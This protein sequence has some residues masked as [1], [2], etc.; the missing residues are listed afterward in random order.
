MSKNQ[1][2]LEIELFRFDGEWQAGRYVAV[3]PK[4]QEL[5]NTLAPEID[6]E[7]DA[8]ELVIEF[9]DASAEFDSA[10]LRISDREISLNS[11]QCSV[12]AREFTE[13]IAEHVDNIAWMF[14][15]NRDEMQRNEFTNY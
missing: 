9:Y 10:V 15:G 12:I 11:Q 14:E 7:N 3:S 8:V 13:R 6:E 5:L 4:C 2:N 1:T